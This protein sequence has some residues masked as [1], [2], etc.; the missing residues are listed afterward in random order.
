LRIWSLLRRIVDNRKE[1]REIAAISG[2]E[3]SLGWNLARQ[4]PRRVACAV[5][6]LRRPE[7]RSSG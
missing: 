5:Q 6:Q 4:E 2:G 1:G 7:F 3:V